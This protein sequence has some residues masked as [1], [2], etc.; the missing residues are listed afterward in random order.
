MSVKTGGFFLE[1]VGLVEKRVLLLR[2]ITN[3]TNFVVN[4][5]DEIKILITKK[6]L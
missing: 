1:Y 3:K 4:M 6:K 2:I 5:A